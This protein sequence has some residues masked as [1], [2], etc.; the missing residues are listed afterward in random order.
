M[1]DLENTRARSTLFNDLSKNMRSDCLIRLTAYKNLAEQHIQGL[2]EVKGRLLKRL[3]DGGSKVSELMAELRRSKDEHNKLARSLAE[4]KELQ[5][6]RDQGASLAPVASTAARPV[7]S[8]SIAGHRLEHELDLTTHTYGHHIFDVLSQ[9]LAR[10]IC[11]D[12]R[13]TGTSTS[14]G[15]W[16]SPSAP[17]HPNG[18]VKPNLRN[19]IINGRKYNIQIWLH[20]LSLIG[21]GRHL[22]LKATLK[23]EGDALG[24]TYQVSHLCHNGA[25]FNPDHL[26]V[27]LGAENKGRNSCQGHYI[28]QHLGMTWHPCAHHMGTARRRCLLPERVLGDGWHQNMP[29]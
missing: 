11:A 19:T 24:A 23:E 4:V 28:I 25:C 7:T 13:R 17:G 18:Y 26:I 10:R 21:A 27:E 6:H 12:H 20:Q 9:D 2:L 3:G 8:D 15:C 1:S 22:E 5:A 16:Q 29:T 14:L